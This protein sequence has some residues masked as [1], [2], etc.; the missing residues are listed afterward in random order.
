MFL[1]QHSSLVVLKNKY[2]F[3]KASAIAACQP[4]H[5]CHDTA[6]DVKHAARE[7]TRLDIMLVI[8]PRRGSHTEQLRVDRATMHAMSSEQFHDFG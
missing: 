2:S 8:I 7:H 5:K 4:A 6:L 3:Q 1:I